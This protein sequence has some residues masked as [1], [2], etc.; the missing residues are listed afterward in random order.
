MGWSP[1]RH[2]GAV[3][4]AD[5]SQ[6]GH[7]VPLFP[8]RLE[9]IGANR[10]MCDVPLDFFYL[11]IYFFLLQIAGGGCLQVQSQQEVNH[12]ICVQDRSG[13]LVS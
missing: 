9:V 2:P 3:Q 5:V 6:K 11:F 4:K 8:P 10:A 1:G 12:K 13:S 7:F